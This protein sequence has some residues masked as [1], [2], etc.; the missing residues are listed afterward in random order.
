M[1]FQVFVFLLVLFWPGTAF[2]RDL[3]GK[4]FTIRLENGVDD[5][6]LLAKF[7]QVRLFQLDALGNANQSALTV[8]MDALYLEVCD[9]LDI[10]IYDMKITLDVLPK[11][12]EFRALI[13][14]KF[15]QETNS[16]ACYV[17]NDKTIYAAYEGIR[18]G[19]LAH[20]TSHAVL[21]RYFVVPPPE[22]LQE[23]MCGYV[24]YSINKKIKN[25]AQN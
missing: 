11:L 6:E 18:P 14:A 13:K 23:I 16:S 24:E 21:M 8:F 15:G 25:A 5:K 1:R 17:Y 22:K 9:Q 20:E 3:E 7:N 4:Y 12:D 10:H 19:I 2:C